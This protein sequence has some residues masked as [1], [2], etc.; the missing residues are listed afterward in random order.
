MRYVDD[1]VILNDNMEEL[2]SYKERINKF[3]T[4]KLL[5]E[6]HPQKCKI[7]QI[8]RNFAFLGFRVFN[9]HKLLRKS[10]IGKMRRKFERLKRAYSVGTITYDAIYGY[11]Q[12]WLAYASLADTY[13]LRKK[14]GKEIEKSFPN[15]VSNTEINRLIKYTNSSSMYF[16]PQYRSNLS[17]LSQLNTFSCFN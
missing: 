17:N 4:D 1:F 6:L 9:H 2:E 13:G 12:G 14:L 7:T 3:L 10:N 11:F 16:I 15:E 8:G 5:I